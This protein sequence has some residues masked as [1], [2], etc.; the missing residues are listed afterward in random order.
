MKSCES[1]VRVE[2]I[3]TN[4]ELFSISR[5]RSKVKLSLGRLAQP[6]GFGPNRTRGQRICSAQFLAHIPAK[7]PQLAPDGSRC[8]LEKRVSHKLRSTTTIGGPHQVR[9]RTG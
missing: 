2:K 4:I 1:S 8:G 7:P 9:N 3:D 6:L 5:P